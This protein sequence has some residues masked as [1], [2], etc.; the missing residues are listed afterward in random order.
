M[1]ETTVPRQTRSLT[2]PAGAS[3][4]GTPMPHDDE[5]A[6]HPETEAWARA[7]PG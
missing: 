4:S 2:P 6:D 1:D 3:L 5:T 7:G